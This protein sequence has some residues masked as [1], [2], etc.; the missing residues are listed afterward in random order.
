MPP[1]CPLPPALI[2]KA[3]RPVF[4]PS[5]GAGRSDAQDG[6]ESLVRRLQEAHLAAVA[7]SAVRS[8]AADSA[9]FLG[10][11]GQSW[12]GAFPVAQSALLRATFGLA[13]QR[14]R[15]RHGL[16]RPGRAEKNSRATRCGAAD[17]TAAGYEVDG[18][19]PSR[20]GGAVFAR[21]GVELVGIGSAR[22]IA[23]VWGHGA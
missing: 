6:P 10:G 13:A 2:K 17:Q 12:G 3:H 23:L 14:G 15:G 7:P 9:D 16:Y 21:S 1:I 19:V 4:G 8:G 18:A 20:T 5:R 22:S 11:S